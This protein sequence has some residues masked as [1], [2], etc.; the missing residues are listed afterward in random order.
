MT[1]T[2]GDVQSDNTA[3]ANGRDWAGED[4]YEIYSSGELVDGSSVK[5]QA[6]K[7]QTNTTYISSLVQNVT[8]V[9]S[10]VCLRHFSGK[11][12]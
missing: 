6:T 3:A 10:D 7:T 11:N 9:V 4:D 8:K 2:S 5:I 12:I 1:Q